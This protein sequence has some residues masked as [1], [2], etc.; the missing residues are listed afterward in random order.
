VLPCRLQVGPRL[1]ELVEGERPTDRYYFYDGL[2][3]NGHL[4]DL[5]EATWGHMANLW[6]VH[7]IGAYQ[8]YPSVLTAAVHLTRCHH[9]AGGSECS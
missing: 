1:S 6:L 3:Y 5:K 8:T 4:V 9:P 7:S 2:K